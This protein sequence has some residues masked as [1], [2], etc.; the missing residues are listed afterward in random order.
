M[1]LDLEHAP[2]THPDGLIPARTGAGF[3]PIHFDDVCEGHANVGWLEVHP[4]N[5]M[6]DGGERLAM[7]EALR[8]DYPLSLHGVGLSLGGTEALDSGHLKALKSLADRFEPGLISE[9]IAWSAWDGNYFADLL[10][11]PLT[12]ESLSALCRNID[13]TQ[14][15]LGRQILIENPSHYLTLPTSIIPEPEFLLAAAKQTGCGLLLDVNNIYVSAT[16]IGFDAETYLD[17]IPGNAVGEIHLAGF[18]VDS[19]SLEMLLI[20]THGAPVADP[21]WALYE[22]LIRRIGPRPTLIEWD[23]DV[24]AWGVLHEECSK[25]EA[26]LRSLEWAGAA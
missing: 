7:L 16:N 21:V 24:P 4:E 3:K 14:E 23:T 19:A 12:S 10:P 22:R 18:T 1:S 20:D 25:A 11:L 2:H 6:V 17:A 13:R 26:R 15:V 5:Y 9:H 8:C